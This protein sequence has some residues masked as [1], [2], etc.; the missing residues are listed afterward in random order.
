[1]A[2]PYPLDHDGV[3]N[4][5]PLEMATLMTALLV[6]NAPRQLQKTED[7]LYEYIQYFSKNISDSP[8][9]FK[10]DYDLILYLR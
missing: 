7:I 5:S 3:Y 1:M 2:A 4:F 10:P 8:R 6:L 9:D